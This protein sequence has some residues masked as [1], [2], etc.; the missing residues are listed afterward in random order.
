MAA[1]FGSDLPSLLIRHLNSIAS[2]I[3]GLARNPV[4]SNI[5]ALCAPLDTGLRRYDALLYLCQINRVIS[6]GCLRA[7]VEA[8]LEAVVKTLENN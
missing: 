6:F 3:P 8:P 2:V 4:K 5:G 7:A 1:L